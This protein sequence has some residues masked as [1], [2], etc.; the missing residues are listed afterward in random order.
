MKK[1]LLGLILVSLAGCAT[2]PHSV[3][4]GNF[5]AHVPFGFFSHVDAAGEIQIGM[6]EVTNGLSIEKLSRAEDFQDR[7]Q[8]SLDLKR[9][10]YPKEW[11]SIIE[12]TT[13]GHLKGRG[14]KVIVS[15]PHRDPDLGVES[16]I[17]LVESDGWWIVSAASSSGDKVAWRSILASLR[18]KN[19]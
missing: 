18:A 14:Y 1:A 12:I 11:V 3:S 13:L 6:P 5:A 16:Y 19:A 10:V 15:D 2:L 4:N 8:R 17:F 9:K 7:V